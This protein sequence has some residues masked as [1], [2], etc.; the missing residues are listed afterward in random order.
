MAVAVVVLPMT[1]AVDGA[2]TV[3]D[4]TCGGGV[5]TV[6]CAVAVIPAAVAV[7]LTTPGL[8]AVTTPGGEKGAAAALEVDHTKTASPSGVWDSSHATAVIWRVLPT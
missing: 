7:M 3:M 4:A 5:C 1:S 6:I 2:V 8:T